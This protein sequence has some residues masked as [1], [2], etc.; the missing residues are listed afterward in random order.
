MD[1]RYNGQLKKQPRAT[2]V[3]GDGKPSTQHM[4]IMV[5]L[6]SS[7]LLLVLSGC[8]VAANVLGLVC[9]APII[10]V[11]WPIWV[12]FGIV[13][14]LVGTGMLFLCMFGVMAAFVIDA[15]VVQV[16]AKRLRFLVYEELFERNRFISAS[17]EF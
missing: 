9:L 3:T 15:L 14:F 4:G 5:F 17:K 2:T 7:G 8:T 13:L 1:D 11:T 16:L 10:V 12:P 6:V